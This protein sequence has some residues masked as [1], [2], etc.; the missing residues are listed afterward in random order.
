[1]LTIIISYI[2]FTLV[3]LICIAMAIGSIFSKQ[4][5]LFYEKVLNRTWNEIDAN[6]RYVIISLCDL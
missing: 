4:L 3:G 2:L 6:I 1:M 5:P